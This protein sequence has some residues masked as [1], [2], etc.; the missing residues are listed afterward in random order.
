MAI[1]DDI[2]TGRHSVRAV[3]V[4]QKALISNSGV[5]RT[6]RPTLLMCQG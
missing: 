2:E 1:F 5:R 4:N 3:V 6:A